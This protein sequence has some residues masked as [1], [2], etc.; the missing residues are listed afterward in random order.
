MEQEN[1]GSDPEIVELKK[2][3]RKLERMTSHP[4]FAKVVWGIGIV[5]AVV[6]VVYLYITSGRVYIEKSQIYSPTIALSAEH[7]GLLEGIYV[8]PGQHV[9]M[10]DFVA[11]VGG[12]MVKA[13]M[14][15]VIMSADNVLGNYFNPGQMV[16]TMY[17]DNN[18]RVNGR[19]EED[20][21][22]SDI[23]VGQSALFTID[24][25]GSK[26][27]QGVVDEIAP[28]ASNPDVVFSISD[29]RAENEFVVKVRYNQKQYPELKPGMSARLWVYKR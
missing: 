8:V 4:M 18:M 5:L 12:E 1:K 26:E 24:A 28:A 25:F 14:D 22:L 23:K 9:R 21:G 10:N 2:E 17:S 11:R 29:R 19:L 6:I 7:P 13:K 3:G 20:K 27:Y 16:V 15:G